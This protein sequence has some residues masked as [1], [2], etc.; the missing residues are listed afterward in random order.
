MARK[1]NRNNSSPLLLLN[2]H[3][4]FLWAEELG[5]PTNNLMH[6]AISQ[7]YLLNQEAE[8]RDQ[9]EYLFKE[10]KTTVEPF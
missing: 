3:N 5:K 9:L 10:H 7:I 6:I 1:M 8:K 4:K 2:T